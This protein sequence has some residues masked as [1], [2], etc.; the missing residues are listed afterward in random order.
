[1]KLSAGV[2][3]IGLVLLGGGR[4]L[5]CVCTETGTVRD[6]LRS[7]EAVFL[8]RITALAIETVRLETTTA[9]RMRATFKVERRWKGAKRSTVEVWTCGDQTAVCTC[10]VDFRLGERYVVFASGQPL[11]TGSCD[12]TRVAATADGVISELDALSPEA[13]GRITTR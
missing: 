13:R 9:E 6:E 3:A 1:M 8:G 10:G 4:L 7:S 12:R 2:L 5:A 11:G